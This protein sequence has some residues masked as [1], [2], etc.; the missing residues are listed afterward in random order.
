[1]TSETMTSRVD[2]EYRVG[3]GRSHT[4]IPAAMGSHDTCGAALPWSSLQRLGLAIVP[5]HYE[6]PWVT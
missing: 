5:F 6:L 3:G 4:W 2:C 1:M